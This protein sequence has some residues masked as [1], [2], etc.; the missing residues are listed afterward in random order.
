M[1]DDIAIPPGPIYH[2]CRRVDWRDGAADGFYH[3]PPA[4]RA[5]GFLHFSTR[6]QIVESAGQRGLVL[7]VAE[8]ARLG[9]ELRWEPSR[10]GA[11]FPHLYGP[12]ALD[13]VTAVHD[14]PVDADGRHVFPFAG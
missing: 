11:L 10:Q 5:D 1:N 2:I 3:A 12:L 13:A 6:E 9:N 7:I 14:L 4:D 8:A